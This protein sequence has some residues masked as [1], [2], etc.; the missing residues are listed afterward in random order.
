[1]IS[2]ESIESRASEL[3]ERALSDRHPQHYRLVF[4]EWA[5]A[6]E[7]LLSDEGGEK[8]RAAALRIQDRIQHARAAMLEA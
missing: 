6:F 8:G 4:L 7:L 2:I 1:M 5:T 3:I